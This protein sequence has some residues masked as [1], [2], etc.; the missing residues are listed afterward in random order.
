MKTLFDTGITPTNS[1]VMTELRNKKSPDESWS[2]RG[3]KIIR[4][5]RPVIWGD[6]SSISGI[7]L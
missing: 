4:T 6:Y 1:N 3:G 5:G 7:W 2:G